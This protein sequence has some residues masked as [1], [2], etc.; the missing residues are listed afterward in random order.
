MDTNGTRKGGSGRTK[1]AVSLVSVQMKDLIEKFKPEDVVVC[2]RIFCQK[3]GL[4]TLYPAI[5]APVSDKIKSGI[6]I[7]V[8]D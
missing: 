4:K 2:G 5:K 6:Q 1:G 3:A 7:A 8:V